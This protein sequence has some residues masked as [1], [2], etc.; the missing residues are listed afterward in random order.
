MVSRI[1]ALML[2]EGTSQ[3][4][5]TNLAESFDDFGARIQTSYTLDRAFVTLFC[6]KRYLKDLL[7]LVRE[8]LLESV[9]DKS[10]LKRLKNQLGQRIQYDLSKTDSLSYREITSMLYGADHPYGY[11]STLELL[12][13]VR[14]ED[15]KVHYQKFI[16]RK[17]QNIFI[18]GG[19]SSYELQLLNDFFGQEPND[20]I[21]RNEVEE[22]STIVA[23]PKR[24]NLPTANQN[25]IRLGRITFPKNHEDYIP[26]YLVNVIFGGYFG[27]RLMTNIREQRGLTYNIFSSLEAYEQTGG[28]VIGCELAK[29]SEE[30]AI[31]AI[32]DEMRALANEGVSQE[33]L[34]QATNYL[35]GALQGMLDGPFNRIRSIRNRVLGNLGDDYYD[36]LWAGLQEL[37]TEK[38]KEISKKYFEKESFHSCIVGI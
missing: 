21:G 12:R 8:M 38:V 16:Q 24:I 34:K 9:F 36:Q 5:A 29:E 23:A 20:L 22:P 37:N 26:L 2:K 27:S 1:T 10:A 11:N 18:S 19:V 30:E 25:S 32:F 13:N 28:L 3:K 14:S 6:L 7:V 17:I 35:K 15:V 31:E 4:D 33:E